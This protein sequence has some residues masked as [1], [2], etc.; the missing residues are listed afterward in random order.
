MAEAAPY[1]TKVF[2]S[3]TCQGAHFTPD[4]Q[5]VAVKVASSLL[6]FALDNPP[7]RN[8][9]F[10]T[11]KHLTLK[12]RIE[13]VLAYRRKR[14]ALRKEILELI[15]RGPPAGSGISV[16]AWR[17]LAWPNSLTR[18]VTLGYNVL[19][20]PYTPRTTAMVRLADNVTQ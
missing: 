6:Y 12:E 9:G 5:P 16:E 8:G 1:R 14:E 11:T 13:T 17:G 4:R 10:V 18:E 20:S 7:K 2:K 3:P 19:G 15:T